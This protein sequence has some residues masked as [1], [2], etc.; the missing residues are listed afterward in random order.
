MT[1]S[2]NWSRLR[3]APPS[4]SLCRF[5][6]TVGVEAA[7][8]YLKEPLGNCTHGIPYEK[9][10]C[11]K[12][13]DEMTFLCWCG[14]KGKSE[15]AFTHQK[16]SV[17]QTAKSKVDALWE[18]IQFQPTA[19]VLNVAESGT[20][21]DKHLR[22][23]PKF[24]KCNHPFCWDY[25]CQYEPWPQTLASRSAPFS[26]LKDWGAQPLETEV[27]PSPPA[28]STSTAKATKRRSNGAG[29]RGKYGSTRSKK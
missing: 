10:C 20:V 9:G 7:R 5:S 13:E 27:P 22:T 14:W 4:A 25:R 23:E 19:P 17:H 2:I 26:G 18:S 16:E 8:R 3:S 28:S 15:E 6:R 21:K 24:P 1:C 12:R 11:K 29:K